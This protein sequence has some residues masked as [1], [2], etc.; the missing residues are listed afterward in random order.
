MP[1]HDLEA[2]YLQA[3]SALKA[4]EY[5]R[6]ADLLRRIIIVDENYKDASR[7]LAQTVRLKRRR[8]YSHPL[9]WSLLAA[10]GLVVMG[11]RFAPRVTAFYKSQIPPPAMTLPAA[12][13][14]AVPISS[15]TVTPTAIPL[16]WKRISMAQEFPRDVI[17]VI[18]ADPNDRDVLYIGTQNAGIYKSIDGGISWQPSHNG[19]GGAW[20]SSM[21]FDPQDSQTLYAG[22]A[23]GG[24]YKTGNGG[25]QWT[26]INN[27]AY[28]NGGEITV[29]A[30]PKNSQQLYFSPSDFLYI[31]ENGGDT[32][33]E[34]R[35]ENITECPRRIT[36]FIVDTE[37][38]RSLLAFNLKNTG[39]GSDCFTG[40]YRSTDGGQSWSPTLEIED[41]RD[42]GMLVSDK[43]GEIIYAVNWLE[44]HRSSDRGETWKKLSIDGC[45]A[46]ALDPGNS[47]TLYCVK[48]EKNQIFISKDDGETWTDF[49]NIGTTIQAIT[50][51]P[52]SNQMVFAGGQGLW[53]AMDDGK[54]WSPMNNG[55]GGSEVEIEF[56]TSGSNVLYGKGENRALYRSLDGGMTWSSD[57]LEFEQVLSF[58][59]TGENLYILS[60]G[61]Y[62]SNDNGAS[63]T[64][65]KLPAFEGFPGGIYIDPLNPSRIFSL[66][67]GKNL[68][69]SEDMG[70]TWSEASGIS[71]T[72]FFD[73]RLFFAH[74][75][76]E[77][78]YAVSDHASYYSEDGGNTWRDCRRLPS[79]DD[80]AWG[81]ASGSDAR[82]ALDPRDDNRIFVATRG[83]GVVQSSDGCQNWEFKNSGLGNLFVNTIAI[84]ANSPDTLYASTDGGAYVSYNG[85][86]TW[87]QV[88]DGLLGAT[89]VYS[90]IVDNESNVLA[91]TPYGIFK[92]E[93]K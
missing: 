12:N 65:K 20:V 29:A 74:A 38:P 8:W 7:L 24:V 27:G 15:P 14:T 25:S 11:I 79:S 18:L 22:V 9:F 51:S 71:S 42:S 90:M 60:D 63:W 6:A 39:A 73:S 67:G 64:P 66:Y 28:I 37:D 17:S 89:V 77:K 72:E 87:G 56:S 31:T 5:D 33:T 69:Y 57:W 68:F 16:S 75:S 23:Y 47:S 45:N 85:G 78:V 32:W 48:R 2:L 53:A 3:Q 92:L 59:D 44:A 91:S 83:S 40:L 61:F 70:E 1:E 82:A 21:V 80:G 54:N 34:T 36:D 43:T 58:E 55:T 93:N 19:L 62:I 10:A 41:F 30:H 46:L 88:N 76:G 81:W 52:H 13:Q 4:R 50:V 86:E 49:P 84:D 26:P 35:G